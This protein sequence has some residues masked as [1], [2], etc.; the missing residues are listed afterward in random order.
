MTMMPAPSSGYA[1]PAPPPDVFDLTVLALLLEA[2]EPELHAPGQLPGETLAETAARRQAAADI[3]EDL[4]NELR[5]A[6]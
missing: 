3:V 6:A 2:T 5:S 4:L 1:A